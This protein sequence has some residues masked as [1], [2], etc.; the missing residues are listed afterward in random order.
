MIQQFSANAIVVEADRLAPTGVFEAKDPKQLL[1]Y[2]DYLG[3]R[4]VFLA[5]S[6]RARR[7]A[8]RPDGTSLPP[9]A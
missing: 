2:L 4:L 3:S 9:L 8:G 7:R 6:C 1:N 5:M